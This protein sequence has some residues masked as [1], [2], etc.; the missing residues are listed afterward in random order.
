MAG[1][2]SIGPIKIDVSGLVL[3]VHCLKQLSKS[4]REKSEPAPAVISGGRVAG[5]LESL[6][7]DYDVLYQSLLQLADDSAAFFENV[8]NSFVDSDNA[9]K[10]LIE[11]IKAS[12]TQGAYRHTQGEKSTLINPL[13]FRNSRI[14][15]PKK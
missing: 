4:W 9:A 11:S 2:N 14:V 6:L 3:D 10:I 1:S 7:S 8:Q 12:Q 15:Y 5:E 13:H